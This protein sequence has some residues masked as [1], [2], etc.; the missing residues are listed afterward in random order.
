MDLFKIGIWKKYATAR[1]RTWDNLVNSE[2]LYQL[3]YGGSSGPHFLLI[4]SE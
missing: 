2:V 3:S 4:A 1:A